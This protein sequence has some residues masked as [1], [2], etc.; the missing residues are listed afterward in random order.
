[1][2]TRSW[3]P[4]NLLLWACVR[5]LQAFLF[6]LLLIVILIPPDVF[7]FWN[8]L[9]LVRWSVREF[10]R[11]AIDGPQ[12]RPWGVV[13][14]AACVLFLFGTF[15]MLVSMGGAPTGM[16]S[17]MFCA[18]ALGCA[19]VTYLLLRWLEATLPADSPPPPD[20]DAPATFSE[21]MGCGVVALGALGVLV[22]VVALMVSTDTEGKLLGVFM[23]AICIIGAALVFSQ[24]PGR[25]SAVGRGGR[26]PRRIPASVIDASRPKT[27][28]P[29]MDA[30][31]RDGLVPASDESATGTAG[32]AALG[33]GIVGALIF[34]VAVTAPPGAALL[35]FIMAV[36][37][38]ISA[39]ALAN[40][41]PPEPPKPPPAPMG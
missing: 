21:K 17:I 8:D 39:A 1:M 33:L 15:A 22:L 20:P 23:A 16:A 35:G 37:C 18:G 29:A 41:R 25:A 7:T 31:R 28:T 12:A 5:I 13:A 6:A 27:P 32:Y 30:S 3:T 10:G 26:K 4:L 14:L 24:R 9:K 34:V 36:A 40:R 19:A 11:R 38:L 2:N